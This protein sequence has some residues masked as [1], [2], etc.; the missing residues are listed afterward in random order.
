MF[1]KRNNN[2]DEKE[3]AE[4][5]EMDELAQQSLEAMQDSQRIPANETDMWTT[6]AVPQPADLSNDPETLAKQL[7][8]NKSISKYDQKELGEVLNAL[9]D[10]FNRLLTQDLSIAYLTDDELTTVRIALQ[11]ARDSVMI[12]RNLSPQQRFKIFKNFLFVAYSTI[13]TSR[14]RKGWFITTMQTKHSITES[15]VNRRKAAKEEGGNPLAKFMDM[16]NIGG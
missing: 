16:L 8:K 12:T 11:A 14:S 6:F 3:I 5:Q 7:L 13:D 2:N 10:Q 4:D 9:A 1:Y 15:T